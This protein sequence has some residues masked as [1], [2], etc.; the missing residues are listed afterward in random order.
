MSQLLI[1]F[2]D[3]QQRFRII[4]LALHASI[5]ISGNHNMSIAERQIRSKK[6]AQLKTME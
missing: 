2:L 1:A 5:L 4:G 3:L 6:Y